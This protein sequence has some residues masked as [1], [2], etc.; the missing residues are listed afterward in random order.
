[1]HEHGCSRQ[2]IASESRPL[3]A[4][5]FAEVLAT[6]DVP[7]GIVNILTGNRA[8]LLTPASAGIHAR[9]LKTKRLIKP[10]DFNNYLYFY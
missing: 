7:E 10:Q 2:R 3:C 9:A 8:E 4:I 5:T 1:M 6:S